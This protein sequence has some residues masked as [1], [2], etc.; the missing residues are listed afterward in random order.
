MRKVEEKEKE[1]LKKLKEEKERKE[2]MEKEKEKEIEI[3]KEKESQFLKTKME[4]KEN[5]IKLVTE[6]MAKQTKMCY[7]NMN[8]SLNEADKTL[9]IKRREKRLK[10]SSLLEDREIK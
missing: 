8:P 10:Q 2:R 5:I 1:R 4:V 9:L 3:E 6:N 7:E